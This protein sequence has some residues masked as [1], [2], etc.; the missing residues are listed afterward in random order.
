MEKQIVSKDRETFPGS[1]QPG[2]EE[3]HIPESYKD[4][5]S[6]SDSTDSNPPPVF[7]QVDPRTLK[8]HPQNSAIYGK[9]EDVTE[10]IESIRIYGWVKPFVVTP[11][12]T[13]ISGHQRCKALLA[14]GWDQILVKLL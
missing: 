11:A 6:E 10:L 4:V 12:G 2:T 8:P 9:S 1:S 3:G 13:I 7:K 14:L 5:W